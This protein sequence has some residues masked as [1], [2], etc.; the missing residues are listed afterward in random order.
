MPAVTIASGPFPSFTRT[1]SVGTTLQEYVIPRG[2]RVVTVQT[3]AA[4]WVQVT[5]AQ[6]DAVSTTAAWEIPAANGSVSFGV[7]ATFAGSVLVAAQSGTCT[8]YVAC[9]EVQP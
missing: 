6:G 5:G 1:T 4:A 3:S 2:T 7:G 9:G 8:V